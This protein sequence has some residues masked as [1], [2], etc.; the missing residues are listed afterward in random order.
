VSKQSNCFLVPAGIY[1]LNHSVGCL[2]RKVEHA[3]HCF[4]KQWKEEG[5]AA[6]PTWLNALDDFNKSLSKLLNA[7]PEEFCP[8]VNISSA[9]TKILGSLPK[10]PGKN[11]I[12]FSALD[13]PSMG[14]VIQQ[15]EKFG[16][17]IECIPATA[18]GTFPIEAWRKI[19]TPDVHLVFITHVLSENSYQNPVKD[20]LRIAKEKEIITLVDIAQSVGV[21]PIDLAAW[22]A[23]FVVGTSV[24][25]LCGGMGA[26]FMWLNKKKLS[27][28]QPIDVGWFSHETPFEFNIHSF[29]YAKDARR[30]L[31]GTPSVL[32]YIIATASINELLTIGIDTIYQHNQR[33]IE[34]LVSELLNNGFSVTS[35]IT[36][37]ERGGSVSV[38]FP[39]E[40]IMLDKLL[41]ANIAIDNRPRFGIRISPHIYNT[42]EEIEAL[43]TAIKR[44]SPTHKS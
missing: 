41:Q 23:D 1:L 35:P 34:Q 24:K 8:Q 40:K 15:M 18:E 22:D 42:T 43:I 9:V 3:V 29:C 19:L 14:F 36:K 13:F 12:V 30:F 28:Y 27:H 10:N 5:A 39:E 6:W 21:V 4:L 16:Y 31:G 37:L 7:T 11:K 38:K 44:N 20:I 17:T 26:A 33:L 32:P 2:P 25:W